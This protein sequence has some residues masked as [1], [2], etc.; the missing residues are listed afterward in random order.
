M[1]THTELGQILDRMEKLYCRIYGE[2]VCEIY[3]YG[4]YARGDE[5]SGSDIDLAAVVKGDRKELQRK[6]KEVW[7]EADDI[8]L[9]YEVVISPTVIP[10]HEF[11]RYKDVLPYYRNI[12]RE[13][14]VVNG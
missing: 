12:V 8:G 1:C 2:D 11:E 14:V 10:Y 13:G 7:D 5:E 6:L 4:S 9:D 3:L